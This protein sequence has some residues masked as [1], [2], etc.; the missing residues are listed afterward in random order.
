MAR[1]LDSAWR[2]VRDSESIIQSCP[3][4]RLAAA[5]HP[6]ASSHVALCRRA[7]AV[8]SNT[9]VVY[10][11]DSQ[12]PDWKDHKSY[13]RNTWRVSL[14]HIRS[15]ACD[16][17][18]PRKVHDY[19]QPP[20]EPCVPWLSA[21]HCQNRLEPPSMLDSIFNPWVGV[22][23]D[24]RFASMQRAG[25][26]LSFVWNLAHSRRMPSHAESKREGVITCLYFLKL[27][28]THH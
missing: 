23:I 1:I 17:P 5:W 2:A 26:Y 24:T 13:S 21:K 20:G 15:S 9:R 22:C 12:Q 10:S 11:L 28:T 25:P 3:P 4:L 18:Q 8:L 19:V 6:A 27:V 14:S 7:T 16:S